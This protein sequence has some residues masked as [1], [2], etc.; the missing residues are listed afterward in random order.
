MVVERMGCTDVT[1]FF[2]PGDLERLGKDAMMEAVEAADVLVF[3][4][5]TYCMRCS[6]HMK[7]FMEATFRY[8]LPHRPRG[9]MFSKRAAVIA[10][11]AGAG[12]RDAVKDITNMLFWWGVPR[13]EGYGVALFADGWEDI[14]PDK[15][16]SIERNADRIASRLMKGRPSVGLRTR[17]AFAFIRKMHADGNGVPSDTEYWKEQGWLEKGR[18]W[19]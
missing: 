9:C 6:S 14:A 2:L 19:D 17:M 1:E 13:T 5:P 8:W 3:T 11:A 10:T 12:E 7:R 16:A 15:M 4:T 18:P